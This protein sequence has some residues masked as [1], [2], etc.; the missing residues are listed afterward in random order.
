V[1]VSNTFLP[2]RVLKL[3]LESAVDGCFPEFYSKPV[4]TYEVLRNFFFFLLFQEYNLES[5]HSNRAV[6]NPQIN[7]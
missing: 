4:G 2:R 3:S 7:C 6:V 5:K 1:A